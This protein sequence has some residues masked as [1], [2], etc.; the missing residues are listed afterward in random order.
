MILGG[1]KRKNVRKRIDKCLQKDSGLIDIKGVKVKSALLFVDE[2]IDEKMSQIISKKLDI[3]NSSIKILSFREKIVKEQNSNICISQKDFGLSGK[4]KNDEVIE[5]LNSN[6]D[7]L[8]N[9]VKNNH[10]LKS[11]VVQ[12]NASFK[13]GFLDENKFIYDLMIE[14]DENDFIIF[15]C[16]LKKYLKILNKI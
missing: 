8:I 15:N 9:Y 3:V 6:I 12:S 1:L 11:L 14:A 7:L 13:V 4:F 5:L 10:Y 2:S 16:E